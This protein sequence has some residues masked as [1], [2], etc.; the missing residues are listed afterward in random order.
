MCYKRLF[1][2]KKNRLAQEFLLY[3]LELIVLSWSVPNLRAFVCA[4]NFFIYFSPH[5]RPVDHVQHPELNC[6]Q[7]IQYGQPTYGIFATFT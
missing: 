4:N 6:W 5:F 1:S 7:K 3:L 2:L